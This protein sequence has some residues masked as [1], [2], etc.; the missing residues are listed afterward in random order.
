VSALRNIECICSFIG[1]VFPCARSVISR[2]YVVLVHTH[3]NNSHR[4]PAVHTI[5]PNSLLSLLPILT[6]LCVVFVVSLISFLLIAPYTRTYTCFSDALL[7]LNP[8]PHS[9]SAP[10]SVVSSTS[11]VALLVTLYSYLC[12]LVVR[13]LPDR[14]SL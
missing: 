1:I 9:F 14:T 4:T 2:V 7:P 8:S 10:N 6:S 3:A 5:K 12:T 13:H 11:G